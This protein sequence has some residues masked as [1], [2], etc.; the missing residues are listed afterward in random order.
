MT[1]KFEEHER[2]LKQLAH[3]DERA[4]YGDFNPVQGGAIAREHIF[5]PAGVLIPQ[6][7]ARQIA[8]PAYR[9]WWTRIMPPPSDA[10]DDVPGVYL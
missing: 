8:E 7:P 9:E 1:T 3:L 4:G 5:T 2:I 6:N 10:D